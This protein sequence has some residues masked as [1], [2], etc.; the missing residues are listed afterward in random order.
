[1]E[2]VWKIIKGFESYNVS[3]LGRIKS[4]FGKEKI[5][6]QSLNRDGYMKINLN[7]TTFNTHRL[8]A[9][10]FL[11]NK[12]NKPQVNH[13]NKKRCD[14]RVENLEW[15]SIQEN[16]DHKNGKPNMELFSKLI[17]ERVRQIIPL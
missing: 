8:V 2:E 1:M 15:V 4:L 6:K 5:L 12:E 17:K 10:A 9:G 11:E 3:N 16:N 14:N 7:G 13:L